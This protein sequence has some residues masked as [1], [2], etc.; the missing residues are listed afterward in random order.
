VNRTLFSDQ[1]LTWTRAQIDA[2]IWNEAFSMC[3][4]VRVDSLMIAVAAIPLGF[5]AM[6]MAAILWNAVDRP[7][8]A[9][10]ALRHTLLKDGIVFFLVRCGFLSCNNLKQQLT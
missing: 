1:T 9:N 3:V 7:R 10:I 4:V 8:Q 5:E 2:I 6:M